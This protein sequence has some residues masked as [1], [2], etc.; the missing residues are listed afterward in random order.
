MRNGIN[1]PRSIRVRTVSLKLK[2]ILSEYSLQMWYPGWVW[3]HFQ[4]DRNK[5]IV[6]KYRT[7]YHSAPFYTF[8]NSFKLLSHF[9]FFDWLLEWNR[10]LNCFLWHSLTN[11]FCKRYNQT[12][13]QFK[14]IVFSILKLHSFNFMIV[15]AIAR[16]RSSGQIALI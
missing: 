6:D 11:I 14:Q 10:F 3:I 9:G 13:M 5:I 7:S 8:P 1:R 2:K 4:R 15:I 12:V 16:T